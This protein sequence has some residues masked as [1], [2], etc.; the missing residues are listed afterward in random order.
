M[1]ISDF[2]AVQCIQNAG[3]HNAHYKVQCMFFVLV[4][5]FEYHIKIELIL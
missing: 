1:V 3:L 5:Q 4:S 2:W